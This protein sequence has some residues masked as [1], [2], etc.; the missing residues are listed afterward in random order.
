MWELAQIA[1]HSPDWFYYKLTIEDTHHIPLS[2][3]EKER[4]EGIMSEDLIQQEYFCSFE[5]G[6][7][8]SYY[9]K[10][11]N[12]L[13]LNN[14]IGNVPWEPAFKVH[15]AIDIGVRDSTSIIFY[16]VVG[17]TIRIIDYYEKS[18]EGLEHYAQLIR[19]KPY[20]YG[21]FFAPHDIAVKEWGSGLT[22][23]EKARQLG[24][25]F[26]T[27]S[28]VSID[29]GIE[30][31]RSTL[32][33]CWIDE[34]NCKLLIKS[35]ENYRQEYDEKKRT[36][37]S[38][39]LH[40]WASH[41][42]FVGDTLVS[43]D[44]GVVEIR[45]IKPGMLV[46]TPFGLR[47]VLEVH[48]KKTTELLDINVDGKN[49]T[50]T[51]Y[52]YIFTQRGLVRADSLRYND[53]MEFDSLISRVLWKKIYS[54]FGKGNALRGFKKNFLTLK[55]AAGKSLMVAFLSGTSTL[56]GLVACARLHSFV[57]ST[58][59]RK[60]AVKS[61]QNYQLAQ[62][63][64]VFDITVETDNC[65]YANGYLV[66][67]SDAMRYLSVSLAKTSDGLSAAELERKYRDAIYGGNS[68]FAAP[69]QEPRF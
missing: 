51:P 38:T 30:M 29:D 54:N 7:E 59:L 19:S 24:I 58:L 22:R 62:A 35:L 40:N 28:N 63:K 41:A 32:P 34:N 31:V 9:S 53:V 47:K 56:T 50:T 55:M 42:C 68:Q 26:E 64:E 25:P 49:I 3:I 14:Q 57:I 6:V 12:K 27:V 21:K 65:Y 52:H 61:V 8:G 4:Q 2:E 43:T 5:L 18:K 60:H 69:F 13:R 46:R 11:I 17:M 67:N 20:L 39:P 66:S 1:Q 37:K 48:S 36:Y 23:L 44:K 33:K 10:Y 45:N 15:V 16:Q